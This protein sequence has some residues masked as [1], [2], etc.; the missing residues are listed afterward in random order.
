MYFNI[1]DD[2]AYEQELLSRWGVA[3]EITLRRATG[4]DTAE[5]LIEAAQGAAGVV[6]E[7]VEVTG[8]VIRHLPDLRIVS[9]QA[10]GTNNIDSGTATERGVCVTNAPGFCVEEVAAHALGL[11]IDI[12]RG[13]T[14]L[15][16]SVR[17]GE[18]NPFAAPMPH[19]LVGRTVGLVF[20][21]GIPQRM[22]SGL[23]AL[24]L[25][26]LVFAPTKTAEFIRSCGARQV[27]TL[28]EL[29]TQSDIVSLHCPL[30][31]ETRHLMGTA[32]FQRM[33]D[34]AV[35]VNTARGAVVDE[36]ALV[37]AL[38]NGVIAGA[39]L[40]VCE[41]EPVPPRAL[42]ALEQTVITPHAAFLSEESFLD[43]RERVLRSHVERLVECTRP[44]SLVNQE[45]EF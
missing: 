22:V 10:I 27:G 44:S 36:T 16:R 25:E 18:W 37:A 19:R 32:E 31:P 23:R 12:T 13:I 24:G 5:A 29:L 20:F 34:S 35:L 39:A 6:V 4:P 8:E 9:V 15:D 26:I 2:L 3:D 38:T 42:S 43:A 28:D 11:I 41:G 45:V 30:L 14:R 1:A 7:Y 21:G 33:R 17:R 40:D